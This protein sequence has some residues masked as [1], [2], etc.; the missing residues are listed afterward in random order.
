MSHDYDVVILGSG[1]GGSTIAAILARHGHRVLML[2]KGHHPRFAL[3]EA[4]LPQTSYWL[5]LISERYDVPEIKLLADARTVASHVAPT[6]GIKRSIGFAF[7]RAGAP[8]DMINDS[9]QVLAPELP[10][11]SESHLYRED[12]DLYLVRVAQRYG[13]TLIEDT[14]VASPDVDDDGVRVADRAGNEYRARYLVDA[15]SFSS[16]VASTFGLREQPTRLQTQSRSIFTHVDGLRPWDELFPAEQLPGLKYDWHEGTLH[17]VFDGGWFWII[18]FG[19]RRRSRNGKASIGLTLDMR[20]FPTRD[21][22]NAE[23][24]FDAVLSRFPSITAHLAGTTPTRP[25]IRTG[26]L[27]YSCTRAVGNRFFVTP[28]AYGAVDAL[29]SRGLINTFEMTYCFARPLLD[30][31]RD[32]DFGSE[33]FS[34]LD[35][36]ARTQLDLHD[37]MVLNAYRSF[38]DFEAWNAWL[39]VWLASKLFGDIWLLRTTLRYQ[40]SHDPAELDRL[41]L[42]TPPFYGPLLNLINR[43]STALT[44]AE[45]GQRTWASAAA[46]INQALQ[47]ADW[48]PN[49]TYA[50]NDPNVHHRDFTPPHVMPL[51][52]MWGKLR[53]PQWMRQ[54]LFD[55]PVRPLAKLTIADHLRTRRRSQPIHARAPAAPAPADNGEARHAHAP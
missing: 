7:H 37:Q 49:R 31:L 12:V 13:A 51:A 26:R 3:G 32:D 35:E 52:I 9:H 41:E 5:W 8:H 21:D 45:D 23:Q 39:K 11:L 48:L 14:E 53:A 54:H 34:G 30:A 15:S 18:P 42:A 1:L 55:F 17:H 6:S 33:R 24:E 2:E 50:W 44:A 43:S 46:G 16:I 36:L 27:Q 4:T 10:F 19:N 47:S 25:Y 22:L 40:A 28:Q 29:Y 38:A 20:K